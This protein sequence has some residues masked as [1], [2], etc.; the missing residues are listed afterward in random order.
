MLAELVASVFGRF[1]SDLISKEIKSEAED[2]VNYEDVYAFWRACAA[3]LKN[4]FGTARR[5]FLEFARQTNTKLADLPDEVYTFCIRC[6]K[7]H[8]QACLVRDV[9]R[10]LFS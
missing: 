6:G 4:D 1:V 10:K 8:E 5:E 3:Y 9:V 7:D 2:V